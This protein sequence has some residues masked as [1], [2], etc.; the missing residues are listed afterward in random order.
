M[1]V[2]SAFNLLDVNASSIE[3]SAAGWTAG[4]NT[5]IARITTRFYQGAAALS[6]TATAAGTVTATTAV[7][8]PVA[9]G[10]EYQGYAFFALIVAAAG[11]SSS[12]RVDWWAAS[13]GGTAISSSSGAA[14][15]M[16]SA[17][18][19]QTPPPQVTAVA[20]AG[21]AF[22]SLTVTVT[23]MTAGSVVAMDVATL[24]IPNIWTGNLLSYAVSGVETDVS[25]WSAGPTV[26]LAR[27]T[28]SV[29]EGWYSLQ[30]TAT[31]TGDGAVSLATPVPV[32]A[33]TEYV[34]W[35]MVRADAAGSFRSSVQWLDGSSAVI[36]TSTSETWPLAA[37]TWTRAPFTAVAP[38]GAVS[39]RLVLVPVA[40][41][42]GQT[43]LLDQ[44]AI[45]P[46]SLIP[47]TLLTYAEQS[48]DPLTPAWVAD[49]G[50]TVERSV[51]RW[52]DAPAALKV[53][54]S[55]VG[56]DATV[57]L[58]R[59][60]P[61]TGRTAYKVA[62]YVYHDA[63]ISKPTYDVLYAWYDSSGTWIKTHAHR[64]TTAV[65]ASW[66]LLTA[67]V[68]SPENAAAL[69]IS[70]R[71]VAPETTSPGFIDRVYAGPGGLAVIPTVLPDMYGVSLRITGMTT[72]SQA[73]W[74]LWRSGPD[75]V[76][77][78]VRGPSGDLVTQPITGD[79][80]VVEDYEAPL[81]IEV[82]YTA[83]LTSPGTLTYTTDPP[84]VVPEPASG[85]DV[86]I[87]DPGQ[88][89][90]Q[91]SATVTALPDW[92]RTARQAVHQ[93]RGRARPIVVT[94]VRADRTGT[95]TLTTETAAD[96]DALWWVLEAGATLLVQWPA[97]WH[98]PDTYVQVADVTEAHIVATAQAADRTWTL[99]LT[100][101]DRPA[102]GMT[103]SPLRTWEDVST[104]SV[105]WQ[106][107]VDTYGSWLDVYSGA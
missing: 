66:Y 44:I 45:A 105:D 8:V 74:T 83:R 107:V 24:G 51:E 94:D 49:G 11:R 10:T 22:A 57:T 34:I 88:P 48:F 56:G 78:P 70:I 6:L 5:S 42:I 59:R 85:T 33:G 28:A 47:G 104:E 84:V 20:P 69:Q 76:Q 93:I 95:L 19:W 4:A 87:K 40:T 9:A 60:L 97:E 35:P 25:G 23:G 52:W 64:W 12:V 92:T 89:A 62:P 81:G 86:V 65:T 80:A 55:A 39:A 98:E 103:G 58:P 79:V 43:W 21:A 41:A 15:T 13:T 99:P 2:S 73:L 46:A 38:S 71:W 53:T 26:T 32:V 106:A 67:G 3:T 101:V 7:R 61:V 96:R 91:T 37:A 68:V 82:V 72:A 50:C 17:T 90:R 14:V 75:G 18:A 54:P 102:G 63:L 30:A 1:S 77:V 29:W 27:S 16:A 36:S 31:A 100:V